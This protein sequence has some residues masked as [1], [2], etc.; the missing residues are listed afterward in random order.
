MTRQEKADYSKNRL[1]LAADLVDS[2]ARNYVRVH[3]RELD[4]AELELMDH[5]A[6]Y[7]RKNAELSH[8]ALRPR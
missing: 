8:M 4:P 1:I 5:A 7:L 3:G 2:L 6:A